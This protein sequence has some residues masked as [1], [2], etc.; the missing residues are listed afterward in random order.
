M[1][2]RCHTTSLFHTSSS[3]FAGEHTATIHSPTAKWRKAFNTCIFSNLKKPKA[4]IWPQPGK[5]WQTSTYQVPQANSTSTVFGVEQNP[6]HCSSGLHLNTGQLIM[7]NTIELMS[8]HSDAG[9]WGWEALGEAL[10]RGSDFMLQPWSRRQSRWALAINVFSLELC[11]PN[12]AQPSSC[13][14]GR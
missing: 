12:P 4:C 1:L 14:L 9:L 3:T 2:T 11:N 7:K 5:L 10:L 8:P 13:V 6:S